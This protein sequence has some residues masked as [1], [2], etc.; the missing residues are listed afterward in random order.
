MGKSQQQ[1]GRRAELELA[2]ILQD[3]GY[4][5]V[6]GEPVSYGS[7]P[8]LSGLPGIHVECKRSEKTHLHE[9]MEQADR[10]AQ[11]F[12]D[13]APAVFHR[14]NRSPWLITM[15]LT[16]WLNIYRHGGPRT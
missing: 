1:K 9:W 2:R 12:G 5:V 15:R 11:R 8:D 3:A 6:A 16:D 4:N 13:G 10:D 14:R 7:V